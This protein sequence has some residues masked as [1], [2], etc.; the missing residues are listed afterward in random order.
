MKCSYCGAEAGHRKAYCL[1]CGSKLPLVEERVQKVAS[2]RRKQN[3]PYEA[4]SPMTQRDEEAFPRTRAIL[5]EIFGSEDDWDAPFRNSLPEMEEDEEDY[6]FPVTPCTEWPVEEAEDTKNSLPVYTTAPLRQDVEPAAVS[7]PEKPEKPEKPKKAEPVA[8]SAMKL[9]VGR[10][11]G[12]M[13]LWGLLTLGIYPTVIWSRIV[14]ELNIAAS[15]RDGE[16]TMPYFAM[17]LLA[18][19]TLMV[20]P[21]V[22][23]HWFCNRVGKQLELRQCD[24]RFSAKDFWLWGVLGCLILVGPFLFIHKLMN[25]MNLINGHYNQFGR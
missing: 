5:D 17:L 24:F 18:P 13:V 1:V 21:F 10:S 23:M 6:G 22:W 12:K 15:S 7:V 20:F 25:A 14:T 8:E 4:A 11:L 2:V 9:P 3:I 19:V 16:R